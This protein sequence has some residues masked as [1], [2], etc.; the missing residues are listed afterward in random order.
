MKNLIKHMNESLV[1]TVHT[2]YCKAKE[3][4]IMIFFRLHNDDDHILRNCRL[5][6]NRF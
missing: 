1:Y 4:D 2:L 5:I 6:G 3:K